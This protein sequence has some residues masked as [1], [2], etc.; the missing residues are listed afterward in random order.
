[1]HQPAAARA[2]EVAAAGMRE[3]GSV[4]LRQAKSFR[5]RSELVVPVERRPAEPRLLATVRVSERMSVP[6]AGTL[7]PL[8]SI[9]SPQNGA[10]PGV[11]IAGDVNLTG[12]AG[13]SAFMGAGGLGG[14]APMGGSQGSG[15]IGNNGI[16]PGGGASGAGTG[17]G[18]TTPFNGGAGANGL[19]VV[20]W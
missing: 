9:S 6:Q 8:A 17:T 5:S 15:T 16:F 19:V 4:G 11:G 20:R 12:S 1:M 3:N 14:G 18:G 2:A 10:S 7:N 13:Q